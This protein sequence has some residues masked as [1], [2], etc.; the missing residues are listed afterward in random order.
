MPNNEFLF[1]CEMQDIM[2][3]LTTRMDEIIAKAVTRAC[4]Q[5]SSSAATTTSSP[6]PPACTTEF[7]QRV[8][9]SQMEKAEQNQFNNLFQTY[10]VVK[11]RRCRVMIDGET[12]N[13]LASLEMVEKL[14]LT[15]QPHP[16]PYYMQ[17]VNS[18]DKIKV[19]E[20]ARIEFSIGLYK[21]SAEFDI[22][23]MQA[24]QLLLGKPWISENNV[25]H[26]TTTNK[27]LL[28]YNG[29]KITFIPMTATKILREDLMR[30][31]RRKNEPF[32]KEWAISDVTIPSSKS[33][34]LQNGDSALPL[35]GT[36]ILQHVSQKEDKVTEKEQ[37]NVSGK[38]SL[39]VLI[40]STNDA[41]NSILKSSI[42]LP[43]THG[44]CSTDLCDREELC[45][46]DMI[47]NVPQPVNEN[48]SFVLEPNTCAKNKQLLPIATEQ[49][50]LKLLSS[51]NTLGYI[52]FET[53]CALSSLEEKFNCAGL[54]WLSRCTCH[55]IG[56]YNCKGEYMVHRVYIC[57]TLKSPFI[58]QKYDQLE[59]TNSDNVV[60]S[61]SPSFVMRQQVKFQEGEQCWLLPTTCPPAKLKPRTVCCQ[62]G[63][64]DEDMAPSDTNNDYK[65]RSFLHLHSGFGYNSLG[66]TCTCHYLIVGSNVFHNGSSSKLNFRF[67]G[68][69]T[70]PHWEG[71]NSSIRS[72]IEVNEHLMESL[73]D[74][75]SNRS[76]SISISHRQ[77]LQ[78]ANIFC[79]CFCWELHYRYGL[80]IHP[81]DPG[82][83]GSTPQGLGEPTKK[84]LG[85]PPPWPPP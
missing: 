48:D 78:I 11:E 4:T 76:S 65:V 50:E 27:Y 67:V 66:S 23:P 36:N 31:E 74:K 26:N 25:L 32:R 59:G 73:F 13:N 18:W 30:A 34:F 35:V 69:P 80:V 19:T 46:S 77:G 83:S 6:S 42:D 1:K 12:C 52:E 64:D 39:D 56:K 29:R 20:I 21:D 47:I 44:E 84:A 2:D 45:D 41:N 71:H 68:S 37:V 81:W 22:V 54:P 61:K 57:S 5:P 8:L 62:E 3:R 51:L 24:C 49:D 9:S 82:P 60:M 15:T 85:R 79:R 72:A 17:W 10:F 70:V 16:H 58:V 75:L 38:S 43:L 14:G 40:F 55:F 7:A 33:E 28:R 53:L 63:E